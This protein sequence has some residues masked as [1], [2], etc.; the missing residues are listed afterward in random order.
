MT[1]G[2]STLFFRISV[3]YYHD[4]Y[5]TRGDGEESVCA[6]MDNIAR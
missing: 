4:L 6:G 5:E 2:L 3:L 1:S